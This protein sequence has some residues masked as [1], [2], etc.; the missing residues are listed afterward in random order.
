MSYHSILLTLTLFTP[1][2]GAILV[3]IL[4]KEENRAK[5][6]ALGVSL[7]PLIL[8]LVML[9]NYQWGSGQ[10]Q[11]VEKIPWITDFGIT[12]YLGVD[13]LS[14]PLVF[15]TTLLT[16]LTILFSWDVHHR[17][18]EYF[19]LLLLLEVGVIG[20]FISL[21][22]F[23]FYLFWEIVLIPMYFLIV[24]WGGPRRRYAGLK[25]FVYTHVASLIMLVG[26]IALCLNASGQI[27]YLTFN[28]IEIAQKVSFA[29]DFQLIV[30][31]MLFIGFAVKIP[32]V[33]FHTWLPDAHVEAPTGGSVMLAGVLLKM[34]GYGLIRIAFS[35]MP[36][37]VVHYAWYMAVLGVISMVYG[38][39]LALGQDDLKKMIA[40]SSVSHMGFV[41]LGM[42]ALNAKGFNGA[43][44]Q[45]FAHGLISGMLFMLCGILQHSAHTRL[46][47]QLGGVATKMPKMSALF[48]FACFASLG[49]PGLVGFVAEFNVFIGAFAT[50]STLTLFALFSIII[51]AAYYLW[52]IERA[53]FGIVNPKLNDNLQDLKWFQTVPLMVLT[54]LI[55]FFGVYPTPVMEMVDVSTQVILNVVGGGL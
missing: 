40:Y 12:Y 26:I 13:G 33:P 9:S 27:G 2:A 18:R 25:F 30:F 42:A 7:I 4:G 29:R 43:V 22:F 49:L 19:A 34:G 36:D 17:I 50:Y 20:V 31:P 37:A 3:Y 52:A 44:F 21:D 48:V 53:F 38:A 39:F 28:M 24:E 54:A 55:L 41:V 8:S 32:V 16:T 23:L 11:F 1:L 47:S 51:T 14:M 35:L 15:L 5:L 10:L 46:I 45:M 6:L